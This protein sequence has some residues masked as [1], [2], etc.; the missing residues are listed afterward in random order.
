MPVTPDD[1]KTIVDTLMARPWVKSVMR[2]LPKYR[3]LVEERSSSGFS[4]SG[5]V[6]GGV[7]PS[8]PSRH[9]KSSKVMCSKSSRHGSG[10]QRHHKPKMSK[11]RYQK[12]MRA[13]VI[14][15]NERQNR[16]FD[17]MRRMGMTVIPPRKDFAALRAEAKA[18]V[19]GKADRYAAGS[20]A[21]RFGQQ[22][23]GMPATSAVAATYLSSNTAPSRRLPEVVEA[24]SPAINI[25]AR[26]N[27]LQDELRARVKEWE[28]EAR[29]LKIGGTKEQQ[30][31]HKEKRKELDREYRELYG[32]GI[33]Y[34][35]AGL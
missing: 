8:G 25:R 2:L 1:C 31:A 14:E 22:L 32:I 10:R 29:M 30:E 13:T 33:D 4:P 21:G 20:M 6:P 18:L 12:E 15:L 16:E 28:L 19:L 7:S 23:T 3:R 26:I 27:A 9:S 34:V 24:T 11:E 5:E 35:N 17:D